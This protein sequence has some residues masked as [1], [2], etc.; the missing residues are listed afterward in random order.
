ME[1][2]CKQQLQEE[3][4]E[5][6]DEYSEWL[7]ESSIIGVVV[8][9]W[10]K[11]EV[12]SL[13]LIEGSGKVAGEEPKKLILQPIP[14]KLNPSATAQAIKSPLP[15]TPS[16]NPVYILPSPAAHST[17]ETPI[18]KFIPSTLPALQNLKKLVAIVQTFATTSKTLETA[19]TAWHRGW[20]GCWFRFGEPGP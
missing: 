1:K 16:T 5:N 3:M 18:A 20:F 4:I 9:P 10:E 17:P 12:I 11:K 13:M 2:H 6:F 19:H 7:S 14:I 8:Y 15:T